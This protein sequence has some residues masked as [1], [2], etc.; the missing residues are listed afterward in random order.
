MT[1]NHQIVQSYTAAGVFP[2]KVLKCAAARYLEPVHIQWMPTN[3]CNMT[4]PFCSC[5]GRDR[6]HEMDLER[7]RSVIAEF[8][9]LGTQAVT[10]TGGGEPLCHAG[11]P[12]MIDAFRTH[13]ISVGLVT[14]GL[15]IDRLPAK[16]V[17]Q[18]SWCRIS[19]GDHRA[20]DEEYQFRLDLVTETATDWSFS[21]VVGAEPR[22]D[23]LRRVV[24]HANSRK[25]THVRLVADL[26]Q[27]EATPWERV[28][29]ALRGMD[30]LVIYQP[31]QD[32][33]AE[34]SCLIGYIKP[35]IAPDFRMYL[36]CGVQYA[37]HGQ[38]GK[39]PDVLCMGS[40]LEADA[41]YS[42]R[43]TPFVVPCDRCYYQ[44]YNWVLRAMREPL[45]HVEFV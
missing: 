22:I 19:H 32:Y 3:R 34:T 23:V 2:A 13:K 14:N 30:E 43:R 21:Y 1:D 17:Q 44:G 8:A 16:T 42:R 41:I 6:S 38:E 11:L 45:S 35:V 10:I 25:F 26:M 12:E 31:R 20:F 28:R 4:C 37:I 39:L 18:L 15:W 29:Q 36:C 9:T 27:P 5:A 33:V 40:A 24:E 7:A